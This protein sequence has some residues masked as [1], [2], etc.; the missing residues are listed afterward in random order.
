M[1]KESQAQQKEIAALKTEL[2]KARAAVGS[3]QVGSSGDRIQVD[4]NS[5]D[6]KSELREAEESEERCN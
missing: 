3:E 1:R 4:V 2:E 5:Q 6:G